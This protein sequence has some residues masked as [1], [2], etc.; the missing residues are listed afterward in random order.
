MRKVT[1]NTLYFLH[2]TKA[3]SFAERKFR[4]ATFLL[5]LAQKQSYLNK[6]L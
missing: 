5:L 2:C 3:R 4:S 6:T 1:F